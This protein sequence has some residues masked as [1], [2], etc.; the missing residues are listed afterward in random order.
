VVHDLMLRYRVPRSRV[1]VSFALNNLLD[2]TYV[3]SRAPE[4]TFP[5]T[6][7]HGFLGVELDF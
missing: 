3:A 5:G 4:G 6:P 1:T 2:E 7:L